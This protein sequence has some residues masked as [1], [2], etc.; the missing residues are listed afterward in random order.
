MKT[1]PFEEYTEK[2]EDWFER[3]R[4]AYESELEAVRVML[5]EK[6]KGVEIGVGSGRFAALLGIKYGLEPSPKMRTIAMKK[7]IEVVDGFAEKLPYD[8]ESFDYALMVTTL[9][10]LDDVDRAFSE[11]H[12]ILK[13]DSYFIN[14]FVDKESE[15]GKS[16]EKHKQE[17]VF[18]KIAKFYSVDELVKHLE[19]AGFRDFGFNQTIFHS[20]GDTKSVEP[21]K[22]G[23]GEGSFVVIRARK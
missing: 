14:G 10:F 17:S 20:L 21:V 19:K 9:C 23:Y 1:K 22:Q 13:P 2:Y 8:N 16:Y 15:I 12:R 5:P 7:G 3:N 18:Y 11:V 6:G 4:F